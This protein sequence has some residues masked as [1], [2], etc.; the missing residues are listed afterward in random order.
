MDNGRF[1]IPPR[2]T[3]DFSPGSS[4]MDKRT[5]QRLPV[6]LPLK[7]LNLDS[8]EEGQARALDISVKGI[9]FVND[10]QLPVKTPLEIWLDVP[11]RNTPWY[12]RGQV[13]WSLPAHNE[14]YRVGVNLEKADL[15][16]LSSVFF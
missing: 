3:T 8:T 16:A 1:S 7:F 15:M 2:G 12:I 5:F 13:A 14:K 6:D 11:R 9:G 10:S 4:I